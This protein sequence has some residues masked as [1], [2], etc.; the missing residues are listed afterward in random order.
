MNLAIYDNSNFDR[1]TKAVGSPPRVSSHRAS[2]SAL[3]PLFQQAASCLRASRRKHLS[4]EIPPPWFLN[5]YELSAERIIN[6][7]H[8]VDGQSQ[9][10]LRRDSHVQADRARGNLR[11]LDETPCD[12]SSVS[13]MQ[14]SDRLP[15][16]GSHVHRRNRASLE[17]LANS[18][19]AVRAK[20]MRHFM[21][22]CSNL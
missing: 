5:S 3:A 18:L 4:A 8:H 19:P 11:P 2:S 1:G 13:W 7:K 10:S 15:K 17:S 20:M 22:R 6:D 21:H 14:K 12:L 16:I 9:R